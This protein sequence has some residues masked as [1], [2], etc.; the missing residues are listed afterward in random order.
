M[1]FQVLGLLV[2]HHEGCSINLLGVTEDI[3]HLDMFGV[4]EKIIFSA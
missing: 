2:V 4:L 1:P 3:H